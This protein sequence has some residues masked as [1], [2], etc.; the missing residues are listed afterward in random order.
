MRE[1]SGAMVW[2]MN[3]VDADQR[4]PPVLRAAHPTAPSGIMSTPAQRE[5]ERI[6]NYRRAG[7]RKE[8]D[9]RGYWIRSGGWSGREMDG[10][11]TAPLAELGLLRMAIGL[12]VDS[13]SIFEARTSSTCQRTP[14]IE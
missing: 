6:A 5:S 7:E 10:P 4:P 2:R 12:D 13:L 8:A 1:V 11:T 3:C 14:V 9:K